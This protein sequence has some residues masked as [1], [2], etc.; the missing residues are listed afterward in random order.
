MGL[1]RVLMKFAKSK[2]EMLLCP[3]LKGR[4]LL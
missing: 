1:S 2:G 4:G 3:C